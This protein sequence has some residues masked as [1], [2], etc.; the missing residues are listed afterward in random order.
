MKYVDS[1]DSRVQT[2]IQNHESDFLSAYRVHVKKVREEMELMKRQS[3]KNASSEQVHLDKI[4][5]LEKELA[6]FRNESL[7]LYMKL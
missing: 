5:I 6:V 2:L 4:D 3:M 1:V 7:K